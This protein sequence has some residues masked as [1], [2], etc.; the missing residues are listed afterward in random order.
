MECSN[1]AILSPGDVEDA[2][3]EGQSDDQTNAKVETDAQGRINRRV[4]V[5]DVALFHARQLFNGALVST[6]KIKYVNA[7]MSIGKVKCVC[8]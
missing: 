3:V 7:H 8:N 1:S 4:Q 2:S 6:A 5:K